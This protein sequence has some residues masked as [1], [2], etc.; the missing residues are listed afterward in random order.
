MAA[1]KRSTGIYESRAHLVPFAP[2]CESHDMPKYVWLCTR[3]LGYAIPRLDL[4]SDGRPFLRHWGILVTEMTIVEAKVVLQTTNNLN[5]SIN[6]GTM[7][8]LLQ[9]E[10][11]PDVFV[12]R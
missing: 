7:Y 9:Y 2:K 8:Q 11:I 12:D 10:G 1:A 4:T 3:P 5:E 6:L